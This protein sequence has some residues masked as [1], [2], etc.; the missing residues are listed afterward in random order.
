VQT[1]LLSLGG[2]LLG[3]AA[4][5]FTAVSWGRL[6]IGG[7]ALVLLSLTGVAAALPPRLLRRSLPATAETVAGLAVLFLLLDAYAA[8]RA[9]LAGLD[10][11]DGWTYAA[12]ATGISALLAAGYAQVVPLLLP[13][14]AAVGLAQ[15]PVL[16]LAA[17][18]DPEPTGWV[19]ALLVQAALDL[20]LVAVLA[21]RGRS[22]TARRFAAAL[23]G[24][25]W[26]VAVCIALTEALPL[27]L[28]GRRELADA[29]PA[30]TLLVLAA[31]L[32]AVAAALATDR[33]VEA[34]LAGLVM[35]TLLGAGVSL[36]LPTLPGGA[37]PLAFAVAGLLAALAL[38]GVPAQLRRG[39]MVA[40]GVALVAGL[41]GVTGE[42]ALALLGPLSWVGSRWQ[43]AAPGARAA[44][45]PDTAWT[46]TAA[47]PLVLAAVAVATVVVVRLELGRLPG[48][49]LSLPLL[50]R[51]RLAA[52]GPQAQLAAGQ[53]AGGVAV[54]CALFALLTAPV[55]LDLP[56]PVAIALLAAAGIALA[57]GA[58][59][60]GR[61]PAEPALTA[62]VSTAALA[63]LL[64]VAGWSMAEQVASLVVLAGV[65]LVLL[66]AAVLGEPA[67][68]A[69]AAACAVVS[70]SVLAALLGYLGG[71]TDE[72]AALPILAVAGLA[73][74]V[75]AVL[76]TGRSLQAAALDG[77]AAFVVAVALIAATNDA[78]VLALALGLSGLLGLATALRPTRRRAAYAGALLLA[79]SSWVRLADAGIDSPEPYVVPISLAALLF[80]RLRRRSDRRLSSFAA[81]GPGLSGLLLPSLLAAIADSDPARPLLLGLVALAVTLAGV[82]QRLKAPLMLGGLTLS[83]LALDQLAPV[84]AALPGWIPIAAAGLLVLVVGATYEERREDLGRMRDAVGRMI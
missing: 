42:V 20:A 51:G 80:G 17:R 30:A 26:A 40:A 65:T 71:P 29:A 58:V 22:A 50:P 59:L 14:L 43:G 84:A 3:V 64:L 28:S 16:L 23:G 60:L 73:L 33:L 77:A 78:D 32:A 69:G 63:V 53:A 46:G 41:A 12:A 72:R 47:V 57:V 19:L 75:A 81:Y 4:I 34:M 8:R 68:R 61:R 9:G 66:A 15:L 54:L 82:G 1:L 38:A 49:P 21:E 36:L 35:A 83:V 62:A 79:A 18:I 45:S 37:E 70:G 24:L 44:L 31:V 10:S 39:P 6:G 7:R 11:A 56:W 67:Q 76:P 13:R 52:G 5:V 2:L 27:P 48:G 25:L 74:G 55:A